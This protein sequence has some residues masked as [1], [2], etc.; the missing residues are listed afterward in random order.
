VKRERGREKRKG[1]ITFFNGN[2]S[3]ITP[4][5]FLHGDDYATTE[6]IAAT[7]PRP[8]VA[9]PAFRV[10]APLVLLVA[11][12]DVAPAVA[13]E[14]TPVEPP[15]A[16]EPACKNKRCQQFETSFWEG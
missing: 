11:L 4:T 12:V 13:P 2:R 5:T 15:T 16:E 3:K 14:T 10:L 9:M 6:K 1:A 7:M 8:M